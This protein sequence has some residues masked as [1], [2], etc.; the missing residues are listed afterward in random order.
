MQHMTSILTESIPHRAVVILEMTQISRRKSFGL[1][2]LPTTGLQRQN[3]VEQSVIVYLWFEKI[4]LDIGKN[5][6]ETD[7]W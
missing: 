5:G 6:T 3:W 2:D 1:S 7:H 4:P